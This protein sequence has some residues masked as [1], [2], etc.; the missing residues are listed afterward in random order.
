MA[1]QRLT[2]KTALANNPTSSDLLMVVD[3]SDTTGSA[4]GTSK[5]VISE[6]MLATEKVIVDNA[7]FL[8]MKTNGL[9]LVLAKGTNK[10]ILPISIYIEYI[11]GATANLIPSNM[12]I[13]H[14]LFNGTKYWDFDKAFTNPSKNNGISWIY[15][16]RGG[17][18]SGVNNTS[19]LSDL[20]LFMYF[21]GA[22]DPLATGTMTIWTTYRTLDI[23]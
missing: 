12:T 21:V 16:G 3:V 18:V 7:A 1:G 4:E 2:D 5:K 13:G 17:S 22:P 9:K 10:V 14:L 19:S 20:D 11:E 23:S 15:Q 6:Y 8:D